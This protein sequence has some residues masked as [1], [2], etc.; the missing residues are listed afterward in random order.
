MPNFTLFWGGKYIFPECRIFGG[1]VLVICCGFWHFVVAF[2]VYAANIWGIFM[3]ILG[4][5]ILGQTIV[6]YK[7]MSFSRSVSDLVFIWLDGLT[8]TLWVRYLGL[9]QLWPYS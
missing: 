5:F 4:K 3:C 9:S 7:K 2:L 8:F 6:V 1:A